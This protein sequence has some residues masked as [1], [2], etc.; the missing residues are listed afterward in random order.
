MRFYGSICMTEELSEGPGSFSAFV[1]LFTLLTL[2]LHCSEGFMDCLQPRCIS[3]RNQPRSNN[4]L[5]PIERCLLQ[6]VARVS[7][8]KVLALIA[9]F[10][11][12]CRISPLSLLRLLLHQAT[13]WIAVSMHSF[14]AHHSLMTLMK[15]LKHLSP[16][17]FWIQNQLSFLH[18][19]LLHEASMR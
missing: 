10:D 14:L 19:Y 12:R 5:L 13:I 16:H 18:G 15:S 17:G 2:P 8:V 11:S 4:G 1:S 7:L 6:L 9:P 3:R